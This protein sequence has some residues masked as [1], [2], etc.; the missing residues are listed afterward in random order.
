VA[1]R[2][3]DL[4]GVIASLVVI[5]VTTGLIVSV[6]S[7][8]SSASPEMAPAAATLL[9]QVRDDGD[10]A[11]GNLVIAGGQFAG[12]LALPPTL[13]VP[14]PEPVPLASTPGERDTLAAR[15]GVSALLG[16]RVDAVISIDRRA[17]A[18]LVDAVGGAPLDIPERFVERDGT[19][20]PVLAIFPGSRVL[21]GTSAA[22]Y[23]VVRQ[24]GEPES[25]RMQRLADVVTRVISSLPRSSDELRALVIS[26]GGSA[27]SS[28]STDVTVSTID[29]IRASVSGGLEARALPVTALVGGVASAPRQPEAE[30]VVRTTMP[31]ALLA[32]GQSPLPRVELRLAGASI[33]KGRAAE[34]RLIDAGDAIVGLSSGEP[35][36]SAVVIPDGTNRARALGIR[37]ATSAGV[38]AG[39]V[40]VATDPWPLP[41]PDAI[42][43]LGSDIG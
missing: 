37:I 29:A 14:A 25:A 42:V 20:A 2:R 35:E 11:V 27:R 12:M 9:L 38:P 28:A 10:S 18:G 21:P 1:S 3:G 13:L 32:A 24:Q 33:V 8:Q 15:N 17:L 4:L 23:A 6:N 26:L 16:I 40:R 22:A 43:I 39:A 7:E 34:Q 5:A 36:R 19:G 30:I 41:Q 31:G